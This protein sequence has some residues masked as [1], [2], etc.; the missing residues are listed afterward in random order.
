MNVGGVTTYASATIV[1]A[2]AFTE[3]TVPATAARGPD[4]PWPHP[5][6]PPLCALALAVPSVNGKARTNAMT[7]R[8]MSAPPGQ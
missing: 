4:G 2:V 7:A 6:E 3:T 1:P 8:L 5:Q